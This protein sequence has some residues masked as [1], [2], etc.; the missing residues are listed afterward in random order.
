L[1]HRA[2][3]S[4]ANRVARR[5]AEHLHETLVRLLQAQKQVHRCGLAGAVRTEQRDDPTFL[6]VNV[7]IPN[8]MNG[9]ACRAIALLQ[10]LQLN[11]ASGSAADGIDVHR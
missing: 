11:G 6:D 5:T 9:T 1:Q 8:G 7:D 3:P 4:L 2:N 10:P